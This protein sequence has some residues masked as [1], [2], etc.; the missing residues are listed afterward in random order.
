[1]A[2]KPQSAT[3]NATGEIFGQL[4]DSI[5]NKPLVYAAVSVYAKKT[6]ELVSG[7]MSNLSGKFNVSELPL[8]AYYLTIQFVGYELKTIRAINLTKRKTA[9]N[10]QTILMVSDNALDEIVLD[11][12]T[13]N[14]RYDIDKKIVD[15]SNLEVDM[16]QSATEVLENVPSITVDMDGTV[17]LRGSSSFTLFI[18]GRPTAMD[19]SVALAT[20]PASTIKNIEIITNPSAKYESE[21]VSG[22]MNIVTKNNKLEGVSLLANVNGGNYNN[23][24]GDVSVNVR[25][26]KTEFNIGLDYRNRSRPSDNLTERLTT[27]DT[28][29]TLVRSSGL[30]DWGSENYGVNGEFS[31]IPNSGHIFTVGGRFNKRN[32]R[33]VSELYF[34]EY[35][36]NVEIYNYFNDGLSKYNITSSSTYLNYQVN[37]KRDKTHHLDFRAVYNYRYSDDLADIDFLDENGTKTGGRRNTEKGPSNM[38]RFNIDYS[39]LFE[40]GM[41]FEAGSQAQWGG[42]T[43]ENRNYEYNPVT[44]ELELRPLFSADATYV[45]NIAGFYSLVKGKQEKFGY[46][47]GIRAEYTD[48]EI[49]SVNF[50]KN[51]KIN[52][53]DWFPTLHLSYQLPNDHQLLINYTRRIQRPRSYY[54]EPFVTWRNAYAIYTGNPDLSPEYINA[55]EINWTKALNQKGNV[56]VETYARFVEDF[57]SNVSEP[58]DTNIILS[59]PLNVGKT[60]AVGIEPSFS[61]KLFDWWKI[62]AAFNLFQYSIRSQHAQLM[63]SDNLNWN[64]RLT[65][66]FPIKGNWNIQVAS[67]YIGASNTVQG[68]SEGYFT[69][70]GSVRK[71]FNKKQFTL[72]FQMRDIFSTIRNESY[73]L[74]GNVETFDIREPRTPTFTIGFSMRLNNYK[75]KQ[76]EA[77][78]DD[79]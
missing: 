71:S 76:T 19:A 11:G 57:I 48:R 27:F 65:N 68:R 64:S 2:Q 4:K 3:T 31:Y 17:S 1:L 70:N 61:Y 20:I 45:R 28:S 52:R 41:S 34:Q 69:A 36:D 46:Q 63:D 43:D 72:L 51:T 12:S 35:E 14:I 79:F 26:E 29:T 56:S 39:K 9:Y 73:S 53:L 49:T 18:D 77:E 33:R 10:L 22:I 13:P 30:G 23:Y 55:F 38:L 37:F 75:K 66:T 78:S 15:V 74:A 21:G 6:K 24:S 25:E 40:N 54:L 47:I 7:G 44:D 50:D 58:L 62:D 67:R 32:M 42:N 60:V 16:G 5:S 8:G 59:S